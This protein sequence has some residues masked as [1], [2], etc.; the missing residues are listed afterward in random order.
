MPRRTAC[1]RPHAPRRRGGPGGLGHVRA[2]AGA[3]G[4]VQQQREHGLAE[5]WSEQIPAFLDSFTLRCGPERTLLHTEFMRQ[6]LVIDPRNR[7]LTGL[8]DFEPAMIGDPVYDFV[9]VG[10]FVTRADPRLMTRFTEAYGRE[11]APR[12]VMA[13]TLLHVYSDLPWYLR[14]LPAS[15]E[16]TLES[17]AGAWF[18]AG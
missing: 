4:A 14:E 15:P 11:F 6:H 18:A 7:K 13:Y 8:L 1:P 16:A 2:Q 5:G 17:L 10:L 12:T 3:Q 9:A